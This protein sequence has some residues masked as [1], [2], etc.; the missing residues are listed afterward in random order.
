MQEFFYFFMRL[1]C[2]VLQEFKPF[3]KQTARIPC[4]NPAVF[5]G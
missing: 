1:K 2:G 3:V 4:G 5:V